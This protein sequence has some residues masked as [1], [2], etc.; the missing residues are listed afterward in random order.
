MEAKNFIIEDSLD[1]FYLSKNIRKT[2]GR[3]KMLKEQPTPLKP[4]TRWARRHHRHL[5]YWDPEIVVR[6]ILN[7]GRKL[8]FWH[9]FTPDH[10]IQKLVIRGDGK[11]VWA[12]KLFCEDRRFVVIE[13][14][15]VE[16][17]AGRC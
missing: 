17:L 5:H 6:T 11:V 3:F 13:D 8:M 10:R 14:K 7:K 16:T 2:F 4:L 12:V 15:T 9:Y 1:A